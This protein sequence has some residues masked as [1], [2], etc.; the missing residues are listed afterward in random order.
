MNTTTTNCSVYLLGQTPQPS[1][2]LERYKYLQT[3][4]CSLGEF[5][6]VEDSPDGLSCYERDA[7]PLHAKWPLLVFRPHA[8]SNI[9]PFMA[10]CYQLKIPVTVRCGGTSLTGGSIASAAG[11]ILL[12][13][14]FKQIKQYDPLQ[15]TLIVEPG[16]TIKQLN[17]HIE[18]DGWFFPLEMATAGVAGLASCLSTHARGY[19]QQEKYFFDVIQSVTFVDGQGVVHYQVPS[20]LVCGAEGLWGVIIDMHLKLKHRFGKRLIFMVQA[21][22]EEVLTQLSALRSLQTLAFIVK[23]HQQFYIG[24]EGEDWRLTHASAF[25][26]QS[27]LHHTYLS[28]ALPHFLATKQLFMMLTSAL[29]TRQLPHA[30]QWALEQANELQLEC[31]Q[32]ADL[33]AGSVHFI[34]Q[35]EGESYDFTQR[36]Q[37]FLVLWADYLDQHK[38]KISSCHGIGKQFSPYMPPFW[39]ED[40]RTHWQA[41]HRLFD[42]AE[43]LSQERFF[44]I[45]GKCLEKAKHD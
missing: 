38:G 31:L 9:A 35:A 2:I 4:G 33:L 20:A 44:P 11:V 5:L 17:H 14:H 16:V 8:T 45:P 19:H 23:S 37:K 3:H 26:A 15:G 43:L 18:A 39:S 28:H 30:M 32:Q 7:Q 36:I 42:P 41:L 24:L 25:L 6:S 34:L 29:T 40:T 10:H 21:S 1:A 22:W 12:T 27:F 13:N